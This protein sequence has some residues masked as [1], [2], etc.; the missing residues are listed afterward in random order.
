MPWLW[1][2]REN[3]RVVRANASGHMITIAYDFGSRH[4]FV[5]NVYLCASRTVEVVIGK[6][7][8]G[9]TS[10]RGQVR[11]INCL[12]IR[13]S[14]C[15]LSHCQKVCLWPIL[16][17]LS[18]KVRH[19]RQFLIKSNHFPTPWYSQP[20]PIWRRSPFSRA[21]EL[22][23]DPLKEQ[24]FIRLR[25]TLMSMCSPSATLRNIPEGQ[26]DADACQG[27]LESLR[28]IRSLS[29][30]EMRSMRCNDSCGVCRAFLPCLLTAVIHIFIKPL[31]NIHEH[32]TSH[33]NKLGSKHK[34]F[35]ELGLGG[36][37]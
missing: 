10:L 30:R 23:C 15:E 1:K 2:S 12:F 5:D 18:F 17:S 26:M 34:F 28:E 4:V 8:V 6:S 24:F 29:G 3:R 20:T 11:A 7:G 37:L 25:Q 21:L 31:C 13:D 32:I 36:V 27:L 33:W 9:K 16:D 35:L 19:Q 14:L 22:S